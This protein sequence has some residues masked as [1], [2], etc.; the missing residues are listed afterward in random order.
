MLGE[1]IA[2]SLPYFCRHRPVN[3]FPEDYDARHEI[4]EQDARETWRR[5]GYEAGLA[6]GRSF[7]PSGLASSLRMKQGYQ[8]G[9]AA[10]RREAA[11][12]NGPLD[13][14]RNTGSDATTGQGTPLLD[15]PTPHPGPSGSRR[16]GSFT[17]DAAP[18]SPGPH[19]SGRRP[20]QQPDPSLGHTVR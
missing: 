13:A 20:G 15:T 8:E 10:G 5:S 14:R 7:F 19:S 9:K 1:G 12:Y 18:R 6:A 16:G 2:L 4:V 17:Q 11:S 3:G